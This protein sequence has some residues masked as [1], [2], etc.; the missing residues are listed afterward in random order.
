MSTDVALRNYET[1]LDPALAALSVK[2]A[3]LVEARDR[4][5]GIE[6]GISVREGMTRYNRDY[7]RPGEQ[8]PRDKNSKISAAEHAYRDNP[9]VHFVVDMMADF[10]CRGIEIYHPSASKERR[11][12]HWW[13]KVGG[14]TVSVQLVNLLYRH[15]TDVI[16][17]GFALLNPGDLKDLD[18]ANAAISPDL[19]YEKALSPG[20]N[21]I[22]LQYTFLDPRT[23]DPL[24]GDLA[25]FARTPNTP[26]KYGVRIPEHIIRKIKSPN[27]DVEKQIVAGLPAS[28]RDAVS[29]G[30]KQIPIDPD[31]LVVLHYKKDDW[32]LW[33]DPLVLPILK[34][35]QIYDQMKEADKAALQASISRIR[36]WKLGSLEHKVQAGPGAFKRL[37][38]QLLAAQGGGGIDLIWDDAIGLVESSTDVHK[39]LGSAKYEPILQAVFMGLG[40]PQALTG[41]GDSGGMTTDALSL[42]TLIERLQYARNVLVDFWAREFALLQRAFG[43]RY[44]AKLTFDLMSLSDEAAEKR[45]WLDLF[46]RDLVSAQTVREKFG[47]I[48]EVE[49]ARTRREYAARDEGRMPYKTGPYREVAPSPDGIAVS[50]MQIGLI[51]PSEAGAKTKPKKK[52]D[53]SLQ[54]YQADIQQQQIDLQKQQMANDQKMNEDVHQQRLQQS[55]DLHQQTL[56]QNSDNHKIKKQALKKKVGQKADKAKP[57]GASGQGRPSGSKDTSTRKQ[58][59]PKPRTSAGE[60]PPATPED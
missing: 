54:D 44:P 27:G 3:G 19:K 9:H 33:A 57:K 50:A 21:R 8:A 1:D 39:F 7:F 51:S 25:L 10:V 30:E 58:R 41:G 55:D 6:P 18:R 31:K 4:Y 48:H 45:L 52:G 29:R 24:G 60:S 20:H 43:D 47:R 5:A 17:R 15:G 26:I 59:T 36:L 22:P 42:K 38:D 46:D 49:D 53:K 34:D 40:I 11:Y 2:E 23:V 14:K 13:N 16:K 56:K 28:I 12:R 32:D 35:L 37:R